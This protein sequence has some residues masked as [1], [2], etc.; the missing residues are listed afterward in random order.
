MFSHWD[1]GLEVNGETHLQHTPDAL[2][3][4]TH[5]NPNSSGVPR[6][7]LYGGCVSPAWVFHFTSPGANTM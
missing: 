1:A 3:K 5:H 4:Q 7:Y 6:M 2:E